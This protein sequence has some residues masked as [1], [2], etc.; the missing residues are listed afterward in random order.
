MGNPY[1]HDVGQKLPLT[2]GGSVV[3]VI[4]RFHGGFGAVYVLRSDDT[5]WLS[6]AKTL[7]ADIRHSPV[8]IER[9]RQETWLWTTLPDHALI[10]PAYGAYSY[11]RWPY[12]HM[13]YIAPSGKLGSSIESLLVNLPPNTLLRPNLISLLLGQ[14]TSVLA[15][16]E[17][18][19]RDFS[20]GDIKPSNVMISNLSFDERSTARPLIRLS[21]FGLSRASMVRDSAVDFVP[22]DIR[23]LAPEVAEPL[24]QGTNPETLVQSYLQGSGLDAIGKTLDIYAVGCTAFELIFRTPRQRITPGSRTLQFAMGPAPHL[25][26]LRKVR[27]DLPAPFLA[28]LLAC[29]SRHAPDRP[30][31]FGELH[32]GLLTAIRLGGG[33]TEEET[34]KGSPAQDYKDSLDNP[35]ANYLQ[36]RRGLSACAARDVCERLQRAANHRVSR[37]LRAADEQLEQLLAELPNFAPAMVGRGHVA[38]LAE[39]SHAASL[40]ARAIEMYESDAFL[41]DADPIGYGA[42]CS[43]T[44]QVLAMQDASAGAPQRALELA[45]RGVQLLPKEGRAR[46]ALGMCHF[47]MGALEDAEAA[48]RA[49]HKMDPGNVRIKAFLDEVI[50]R[51]RLRSHGEE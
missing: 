42:A 12:V 49:G 43:T 46:L 38:L 19:V 3:T 9:F 18:T 20:H 44:A 33:R 23:Y 21:D 35:L 48:F 2:P 8:D 10:L 34:H 31:S 32:Q 17:D 24:L 5:G 15:F 30:A 45:R 28:W 26:V 39:Q 51:Q 40:F 7:R 29:L 36:V 6:A 25:D 50:H 27:P 13:E 14:L 4:D 22:G 41:R 47:R 37:H 11:N 16:L 1:N